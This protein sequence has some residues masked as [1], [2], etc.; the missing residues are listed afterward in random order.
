MIP[1]DLEPELEDIDK[2]IEEELFDHFKTGAVLIIPLLLTITVVAFALN[3]ISKIISPAVLLIADILSLNQINGYILEASA[4]FILLVLILAIGFV[5]N[6]VPTTNDIAEFF[7]AVVES[8]PG[9]GSIYSSVR[10]MGE[11]IAKGENSFRDVK[12]VEYPNEGSYT[13]AFTTAQTPDIVN[14][15]VGVDEDMLTMFMPMGPNPFMG[16]FVIYVPESNVF[17]IDLSVEQGIQAVITSGVTLGNS[18]DGQSLRTELKNIQD[19]FGNKRK[20]VE[21]EET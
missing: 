10:Q 11:T 1:D 20:S 16:G 14:D 18:S 3:F 21:E 8:V 13:F 9:I 17:D 7:H 15:A 12:I 4:V 5:A 6:R 2:P 19:I